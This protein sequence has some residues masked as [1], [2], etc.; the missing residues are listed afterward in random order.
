VPI[1][2]DTGDFRLMS[3][4]VVDA[5]RS[6]PERDRFVRGMFSWLG[7]RQTAVDFHRDARTAGETKYG[8][9][10]M[11][12]LATDG[13]VGFSD[14]PLRATLWVGAA[15][16]GLAVLYGMIVITMSIFGWGAL[17][18]GWASLAALTSLLAGMNMITIG[19]V[20]LYVGRIHNEAKQRPLYV[21]RQEIGF[22]RATAK[23]QRPTLYKR[24]RGDRADADKAA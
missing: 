14:A 20:G 13:I 9:R 15:V 18:P 12:R 4:R 10:K 1:P 8:W 11:F 24:R 23:A 21:V 7:F 3:R 22:D 16:S 2:L 6:M 5:L 17:V 19:V